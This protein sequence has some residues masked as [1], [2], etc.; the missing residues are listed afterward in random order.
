MRI[1]QAKYVRRN[2]RTYTIYGPDY[3]VCDIAQEILEDAVDFLQ[4]FLGQPG[5]CSIHYIV[6]N[7]N[8]QIVYLRGDDSTGP[9]VEFRNGMFWTMNTEWCSD[10]ED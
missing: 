5:H 1:L 9:T 7:A 3:Q 4:Y 6:F 10:N 8:S 2:G